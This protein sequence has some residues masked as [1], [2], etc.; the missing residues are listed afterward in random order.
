VDNEIPKH[1]ADPIRLVVLDVDGVLTDGGIYLGATRAGERLE[2]KRFEITDGLGIRLLRESGIEVAI[3]TGRESWAVALRADELGIRE[4]HQD[5]T[6]KKLPIVEKLIEQQGISWAETAYLGDDLPDLPVMRKVGLPV[7]VANAVADVKAV[8]RWTTARP[9]GYGAT[10]D[11]AEA[12][13]RA[14]GEWVSR[15]DSYLRERVV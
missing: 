15:V 9:G 4:C 11:F 5:R 1:L 13:L 14:R 10:R 6:A 3:V 12:L 7:A 8:A 2:L